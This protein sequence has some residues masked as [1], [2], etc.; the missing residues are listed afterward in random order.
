MRQRENPPQGAE[1]HKLGG[2]LVWGQLGGWFLHHL[3][4]LLEGRA[5]GVIREPQDRQL[6]LRHT[7]THSITYFT[8]Y[9]YLSLR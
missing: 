1:V 9:M 6:N 3:L 4:Q 7:H 2:E 5:P 8:C